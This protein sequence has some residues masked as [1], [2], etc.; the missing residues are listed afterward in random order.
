MSAAP[1]RAVMFDID[2]TLYPERDFVRSGYDAVCRHIREHMS[3]DGP[4]EQWLWDRFLSGQVCGAFN[5]L[6]ERFGLNLDEGDV[7]RLVEVYRFHTPGIRPYD[8]IPRLLEKISAAGAV[9]IVSDGPRRQQ[10]NK[11]EAL[12]LE[13]HF[14][15]RAIVLTDAVDGGSPK[16][17]PAGF[18]R[19]AAALE[20]AH[21]S[22]VYVADNP[23]KDFL[24]PNHLGW[25]TIQCVRDGQ[26]HSENQA[27]VGGSPRRVVRGGGE[28]E[29]VLL[30]GKG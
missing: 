24:A 23:A 5:A 12:G 27:P 6:S 4:F 22:C 29:V 20:V 2:D 21:Q 13:K 28:L 10:Q 30:G 17:S 11:L 3:A 1:P 16:P 15:S 18:E 7:R 14:P 9:G 26:V 25:L 8:D 19:A